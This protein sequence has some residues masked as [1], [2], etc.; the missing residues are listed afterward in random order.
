MSEAFE[1]VFINAGLRVL[2]RGFDFK[3]CYMSYENYSNICRNLGSKLQVIDEELPG[4]II[5]VDKEPREVL[6]DVSCNNDMLIFVNEEFLSP[7]S[8]TYQLNPA[9]FVEGV[10]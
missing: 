5:Y 4:I 7:K 9:W 8:V 3:R 10:K 2:R 1:E 6:P